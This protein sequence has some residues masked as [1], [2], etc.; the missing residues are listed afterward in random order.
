[1]KMIKSLK[2][3]LVAAVVALGLSA[4]DTPFDEIKTLDL[5]RCLEPMNLNARVNSA[6]GDVVTF[7]WD[8]SKDADS[9]ILTVYTDAQMTQKYLSESV[10]PSSVPYVK[11]L[12]ADQ[13]YYFTV[14]ATADRK[15][16]SKVAA[17]EKSIKTFAVKDNL[18]L[19]VADRTAGAITVKWSTDVEDYKEVTQAMI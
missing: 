5:N 16:P 9:Y 18:Y 8:V 17:F 6:L 4:C 2:Y 11:K 7:S 14:Q 3:V 15:Q 1:M 13:T 19:K 10:S 12:D